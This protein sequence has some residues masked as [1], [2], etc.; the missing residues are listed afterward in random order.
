MISGERQH[1]GRRGRVRARGLVAA[2]AGLSAVLALTGTATAEAAPVPAG[3]FAAQAEAL[4]LTA[5]EAHTLQDRA[6]AYLAEVGGTQVAA[7]RIRMGAGAVLTLALPTT[8][9]ARQG[10][11]PGTAAYTCGYGHF[12]AYSDPYRSGDVIDMYACASYKIP[13]FGDGSWENNQ[14]RGTRAQFRDNQFIVRWTDRGAYD[15]D[16]VADWSWVHYVTN[17]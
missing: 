7:N 13:W 15:N 14:T 11:S 5:A 8:A 9:G 1:P 12:C 4:G 10:V 16:D 2:A 3:G 17:C 6:D